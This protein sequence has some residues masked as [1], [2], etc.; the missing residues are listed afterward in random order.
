MA[1]GVRPAAVLPHRKQVP[2]AGGKSA[3]VIFD[4]Q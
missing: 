1:I 2:L 4:R 3:V